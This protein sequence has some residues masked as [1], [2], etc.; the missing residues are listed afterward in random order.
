MVENGG[1]NAIILSKTLWANVGTE[2]A[3]IAITVL[4]IDKLI[5]RRDMEMNKT[6]LIRDFCSE[7]RDAA[8]RALEE[9]RAHGWLYDGSLQYADLSRCSLDGAI[10]TQVDFADADLS[11]ASLQRADLSLAILQGTDLTSTDLTEACLQGADLREANLV[12]ANLQ[13]ANLSSTNLQGAVFLSSN[14]KGANLNG[15]NLCEAQLQKA[16]NLSYK[17]LVTA[18]V[19]RGAYMTDGSLYDGRYNLAGD[20][21]EAVRGGTNTDSP[22]AMAEYYGVSLGDYQRDQDWARENLAK[23]HGEAGDVSGGGDPAA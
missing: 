11:L 8:I 3:S 10:L 14:L 9:L 15:A 4:L 17:Q 2:L 5:Q 1:F 13:D 20:L 21:L 23:L 7:V 6:R 18:S 12:L 19:L 16:Q 22:V